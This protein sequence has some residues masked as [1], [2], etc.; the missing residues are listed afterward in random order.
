MEVIVF[1][2][3]GILAVVSAVLVITQKNTIYSA[4]SLIATMFSIAVLFLLLEA[5]FV[6]AVQVLV[7]AGAIMILFL[8]AI[9]L[10]NVKYEE[11][12]FSVLKG[13]KVVSII[14]AGI[15]FLEFIYIVFI[16]KAAGLPEK[17]IPAEAGNVEM[18]GKVLFTKYLLPF[19]I[20]SLVL[21]VAMVGVIVL[22]KRHSRFSKKSLKKC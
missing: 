14:I 5:Q 1:Y 15:L 12:A 13:M 9:M 8:F 17:V 6:A 19:E 7:Y 11:K 21:L 2:I 4:L 18:I 3:F 22:A 16:H 10:L 20:A